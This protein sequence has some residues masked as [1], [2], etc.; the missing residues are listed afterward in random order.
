[1]PDTCVISRLSSDEHNGCGRGSSRTIS[2]AFATALNTA[3]LC[4]AAQ[5][6]FSE[7]P[8]T[9]TELLA[10]GFVSASDHGGSLARIGT[11]ALGNAAKSRPAGPASSSDWSVAGHGMARRQI[12]QLGRG[13]HH[14]F[15]R[16]TGTGVDLRSARTRSPPRMTQGPQRTKAIR[17]GLAALSTHRSAISE[18]ICLML[19]DEMIGKAGLA[20][21]VCCA[22]RAVARCLMDTAFL[23]R[24]VG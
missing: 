13:R 8:L 23:R 11:R 7:D 10:H 19:I 12:K 16:G 21:P 9:G 20:E 14:R 4:V 3:D 2:M 15:C 24:S 22:A 17:R 6:R 18:T 1:M 5:V